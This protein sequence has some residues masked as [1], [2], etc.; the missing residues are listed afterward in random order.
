M[1]DDLFALTIDRTF[2]PPVFPKPTAEFTPKTLEQWRQTKPD[3]RVVEGMRYQC[4][5]KG[6][7][8][9]RQNEWRQVIHNWENMSKG[10]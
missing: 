1:L 7:S 8:V 6:M 3:E 5:Q 9:N 4:A 10:D 2:A